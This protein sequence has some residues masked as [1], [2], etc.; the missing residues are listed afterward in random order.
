MIKF[1]Y[2][3]HSRILIGWNGFGPQS[4]IIYAI[5]ERMIY[6]AILIQVVPHFPRDGRVSKIRKREGG[7]TRR[8]KSVKNARSIIP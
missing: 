5:Q 6:C 1:R 3:A 2:N 4:G 7:D 8:E